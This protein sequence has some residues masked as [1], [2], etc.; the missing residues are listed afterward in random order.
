M[1][2]WEVF[3]IESGEMV[4]DL[5][6]AGKA[7]HAAKERE[8]EKMTALYAAIVAYCEDGGSEMKAAQLAGV[9]RMTVRRALGK[10]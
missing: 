6:K 10:R 4:N 2:L 9:D 1:T 8:R 3:L 5:T 7:W